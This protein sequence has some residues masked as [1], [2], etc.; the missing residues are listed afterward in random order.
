MNFFHIKILNSHNYF[1]AS[2]C[3]WYF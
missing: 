3:W 1:T 2:F